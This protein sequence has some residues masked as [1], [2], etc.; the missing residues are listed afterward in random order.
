MILRRHISA[1]LLGLAL[2]LSTTGC[3]VHEFPREEGASRHPFLL[4][5]DINSFREMDFYQTIDYRTRTD[6]DAADSKAT[7]IT[8][9]DFDLRYTINVY[10]SDT[11]Q[12][13]RD[14]DTTIVLT[15]TPVGDDYNM[16]VSLM[17]ENSEYKFIAWADF[18]PRGTSADYF[19]TT[20]DFAEIILASRD[21]HRANTDFRDGFR[22]EQ[23]A[24]IDFTGAMPDGYAQEA[25]MAMH[26]PMA[27]FK[28]VSTDLDDFITRVIQIKMQQQ[29]LS[30]T[31]VR[32]DHDMR[33]DIDLSDYKIVFRYTGFMPCSLNMY[34]NKPADAWTGISFES[35]IAKL[36]ETEAELGFD[37]VFVNGSESKV[38]VAVEV[39][40]E[41]GNVMA[42]INPIDVPLVRNKLT[43]VRG[44]FLTATASGGASID[45]GFDGDYNIIIP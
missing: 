28:F 27:K 24:T 29:G 10:R 25:T 13:T 26:R 3:S 15:K 20:S 14:A 22:G 31:D 16:D 30:A 8:L 17:L 32:N 12:F 44:A 19:Y 36:S 4:H 38:S 6:D 2:L 34:T 43:V 1:L 45:P 35:Q 9:T 5:L 21:P 37:Y 18:V 23:D 7:P 41:T 11:R 42:R 40:D 39:Q 33:A